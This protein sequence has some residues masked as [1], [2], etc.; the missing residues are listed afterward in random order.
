MGKQRYD[1]ELG[2]YS[3]SPQ[4]SEGNLKL[5][6]LF[7]QRLHLLDEVLESRLQLMPHLPLHLL[8]VEVVSVVHMLV[9]AQVCGDLADL[10]VELDVCVTPLTEHYGV[11]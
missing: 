1:D 11:L 10:G 6:L 5:Q 8:G 9:F 3:S 4:V 7:R 2:K